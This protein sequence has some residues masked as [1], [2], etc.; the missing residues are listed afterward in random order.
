MVKESSHKF[1]LET[2]TLIISS[3]TLQF[4]PSLNSVKKPKYISRTGDLQEFKTKIHKGH[5]ISELTEANYDGK[6]ICFFFKRKL[7]LARFE[8]KIP[9][10]EQT[11]EKIQSIFRKVPKSDIIKLNTD[12]TIQKGTKKD[13]VHL[14]SEII[15]EKELK[16]SIIRLTNEYFFL[17]AN[18]KKSDHEKA[19]VP[20]EEKFAKLKDKID[21]Q[22][23]EGIPLWKIR[24]IKY[25]E[26][27]LK[28]VYGSK[29]P[30]SRNVIDIAMTP[31]DAREI[32]SVLEEL[33]GGEKEI[34]RIVK[35]NFMIILTQKHISFETAEHKPDIKKIR[36]N[37]IHHIDYNNEILTLKGSRKRWMTLLLQHQE[38]RFSIPKKE[39]QNLI[40]QINIIRSQEGLED[41]NLI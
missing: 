24:N 13:Q 32:A 9:V 39:T 30:I 25:S 3:N 34:F 12:E 26:K 33:R 11:A 15:L 8:L 23:R 31:E 27:G 37:R 14:S 19:L 36:L 4:I 2:G 6:N 28:V 1:D 21:T 20:W 22:L 17:E 38:I 29:V 16:E 41:L 5:P 18:K 40:D 7:R 10:S 35:G